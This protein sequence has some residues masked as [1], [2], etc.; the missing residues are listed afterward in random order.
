MTTEIGDYDMGDIILALGS[1]VDILTR[2]NWESM[3]KISLVWS[4]IQ[5]K[6]E[7]KS[8]FLP[9]SRLRK[10]LVEVE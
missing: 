4:P 5:L 8:K 7:N 1:D 3:G 6:L 2:K 9:I 10:L